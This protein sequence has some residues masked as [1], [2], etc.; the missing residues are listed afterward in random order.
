M[1]CG[2][3][4]IRIITRREYAEYPGF[5]DF[6]PQPYVEEG[7]EVGSNPRGAPPLT[8]DELY[9]IARRVLEQALPP[10]HQLVLN[11][12][13]QGLLKNCFTYNT[14]IADDVPINGVRIE[15]LALLP[16]LPESSES[17]SETD[18]QTDQASDQSAGSP[19]SNSGLGLKARIKR[20]TLSLRA[21]KHIAN[22]GVKRI[23]RK[24]IRK[25]IRKLSAA[26]R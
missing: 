18:A 16:G 13:E 8:V 4:P 15:K 3:S 7:E 5:L 25:Q 17:D 24:R 26:L 12:D 11:F 23:E 20:L 14:L 2:E 9:E 10:Y 22:P 6:V 19:G 21:T 1:A